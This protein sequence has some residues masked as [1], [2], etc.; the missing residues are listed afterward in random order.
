MPDLER[1]AAG[2]VALRRHRIDGVS[3]SL[4]GADACATQSFNGRAGRWPRHGQAFARNCKPF[5]NRRL[6]LASVGQA[7]EQSTPVFRG[8]LRLAV[9]RVCLSRRRPRVRVPS[10]PPN[11]SLTIHAKN[12]SRRSAAGAKADHTSRFTGF[13]ISPS[14]IPVVLLPPYRTHRRLR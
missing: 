11:F 13:S 14:F 1:P 12:L 7:Q 4:G 3:R 2:R 8:R 5:R 6:G 9:S 10:T